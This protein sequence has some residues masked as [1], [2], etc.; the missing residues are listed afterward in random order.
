[1]SQGFFVAVAV[2]FLGTMLPRRTGTP[3]LSMAAVVGLAGA[4]V[5]ASGAL[6]LGAVLLAQ[7]VYLAVLAGLVG[8]AASRLRAAREAALPSFVMVPAGVLMGAAGAALIIASVS[9]A[10]E[11]SQRLGRGLVSQGLMLCLVLAVAPVLIPAILR[12][13]PVRREGGAP[14]HALA[15][16]LLAASF[17]VEEWLSVRW[18]LLAR[19]AVVAGAL[20]AA[21]ILGPATRPG[22]HRAAFRLALLL[23]P[24]GLLAAGLA[25]ER[26]VA[27]L[28]ITHVGGL[29]LLIVAV[30]LH[31]TLMHG[32]RERVADRWPVPVVVAVTCLL[33][34][35]G[36]RATL[37]SFGAT[38]TDAMSLAGA[39]W[40]AA[41]L[42]WGGFLLRNLRSRSS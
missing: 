15:A 19:G 24:L 36:L 26:R 22:A 14:L 38:Y 41:V 5:V 37:E 11:W 20:V 6:L 16:L 31:V 27:L 29:A 12:G 8:A 39:L 18:G 35:A 25:P 13:T 2:G 33:A 10:G 7:I 30:T 42:L 17:A 3:P 1:M 28:H 34:A 9:G 4:A 23:V 32:G 40:V 21:G